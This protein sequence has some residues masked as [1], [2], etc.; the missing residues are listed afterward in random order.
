MGFMHTLAPVNFYTHGSQIT[1]AHGHL[2]FYGAYVMVVLAIIS[3]TM[4][5]MRGRVANS[6]QA[7]LWETWA[8]WLMT[9]SMVVIT[10][11][12]TG[13]GVMQVWLQRMSETPMSFMATQAEL[14]IFY[15]LRLIGGGVFFVGLIV[16][17]IS[18]FI[19]GDITYLSDEKAFKKEKVR[20]PEDDEVNK[21]VAPS[22]AEVKVEEEKEPVVVEEETKA[23]L[24]PVS[25]EPSAEPKPLKQN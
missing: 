25:T 4:P 21:E 23:E 18:F 22:V 16:Y 1:A 14:E 12:L 5:I 11:L 24:T 20:V 17:V 13:A 6:P 8:F 9:V 2:A 15:W 19:K 10:L 7:Q 3:Y